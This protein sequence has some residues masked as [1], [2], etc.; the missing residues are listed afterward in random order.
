MDVVNT[1][2]FNYGGGIFFIGIFSGGSG[3]YS[4]NF[5]KTISIMSVSLCTLYI[6]NR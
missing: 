4:R 3:E 6:T 1:I 2:K 5:I